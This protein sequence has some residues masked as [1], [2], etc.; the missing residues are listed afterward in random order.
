MQ[1]NELLVLVWWCD[2]CFVCVCY[3]CDIIGRYVLLIGGSL[4]PYCS[5]KFKPFQPSI[6]STRPTHEDETATK[7]G[8]GPPDGNLT[9][10]WVV[11]YL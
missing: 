8:S 2:C 1:Q 9:Y 10:I 4:N 5:G 11:G 6:S 7:T 3:V